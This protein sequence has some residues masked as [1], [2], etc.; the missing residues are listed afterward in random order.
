MPGAPKQHHRHLQIIIDKDSP[1]LS[2]QEIALTA[3]KQRCCCSHCSNK[4]KVALLSGGVTII[5]AAI[6][7]GVT[8][9]LS[10]CK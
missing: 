4:M 7:A 1:V 9:A 2:A 5:G 10:N 3:D 8:I 6:S